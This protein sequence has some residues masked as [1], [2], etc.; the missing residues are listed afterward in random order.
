MPYE[1]DQFDDHENLI[2]GAVTATNFV[3]SES[4]DIQN[5][6]R[7]FQGNIID[8][9]L[10]AFSG[11]SVVSGLMVGTAMDQLFGM[12]KDFL[13]DIDGALQLVSFALL[14]MVLFTNMVATFVGVAQVYHTY[15]LVSAGPTGFEMAASYYL[16]KNI[17]FYR[18]YAIKMMLLSLPT[19]LVSIGLRL[20]VKVDLDTKGAPPESTQGLVGIR[21]FGVTVLGLI[22]WVFWT[23]AGIL[24]MYIHRKHSQVFSSSYEANKQYERPLLTK[25]SAMGH[26][27]TQPLDM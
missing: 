7:F 4:M 16:N 8:K 12:K 9:R 20:Q 14:S 1:N 22:M 19:S 17:A 13:F 23:I 15:R 2:E 6:P 24:L 26:R 10:A 25:I 5:D 11:L 27:Q 18:H 3:Q 21:V